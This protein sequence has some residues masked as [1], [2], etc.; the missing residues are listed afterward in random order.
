[1]YLKNKALNKTPLA[2]MAIGVSLI[3]GFDWFS[4]IMK[5]LF[6]NF[7]EGINVNI[8]SIIL[9]VIIIGFSLYWIHRQ[10]VNKEKGLRKK[11]TVIL[12]QFSIDSS[13][14]NDTSMNPKEVMYVSL[15][16]R[17][18]ESESKIEW[19]EN[20]LSKQK[21]A[22]EDYF[23][24]AER[25][26]QP[27]SQYEGLA[28]IP[29]VF[30]LGHQVSDKRNFI[31]SEW[32]ENKLKWGI[33]PEDISYPKLD[34]LKDLVSENFE[35][36]D[37]NILIS[38]TEEIKRSQLS[39]IPA[40][41]NDIY[42]L[43]LRECNR[44]AIKSTTQLSEYKQQFRSLLDEINRLYSTNLQRVNVFISAQTSLVFNLGSAITRN[45]KDV[46]IY[47]FES[48]NSIMY[49]WALKVHKKTNLNELN[50][51]IETHEEE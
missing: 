7:A 44:H 21:E 4:F 29:F 51:Y 15:D 38:L 14:K 17:P 23:Y 45:D 3:P 24:V 49:P 8:V 9:A 1:M 16:Q 42:H 18:T 11:S 50:Y 47:N 10:M 35:S 25:W 12:K 34:L 37:V 13:Q 39:G 20:S 26:D 41:N 33:L 48:K 6:P 46:F 27:Q 31:F 30:L 28:H 40:Y 36:S 2:L 32:D 5:L 22:I 19:I 43:K